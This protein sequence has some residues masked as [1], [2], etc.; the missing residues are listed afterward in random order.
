MITFK[1][2]SL[3]IIGFY[4]FVQLFSIV[5]RLTGPQ[6]ITVY[7]ENYQD[8]NAYIKGYKIVH[9]KIEVFDVKVRANDF[10]D[11][12]LLTHED[13]NLLVDFLKAA[14]GLVFAWYIFKLNY[15]N[16]FSKKSFNLFWLGLFLSVMSYVAFDIGAAHTSDFYGDLYLTKG[17]DKLADYYF[18]RGLKI[19]TI[20]HNYWM[21]LWVPMILI[22]FYKTFKKHHEGEPELDWF[23]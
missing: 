13:E 9:S 20:L 4:I 6:T 15:D 11:R 10:W 7:K 2:I 1:S 5:P 19:N 3:I 16:L 18:E 12:I 22:N 17:G 14:S 23:G 21:Y 8:T